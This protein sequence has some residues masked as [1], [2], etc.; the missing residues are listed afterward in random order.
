[1]AL[2]ATPFF[3]TFFMRWIL[4][5]IKY[6]FKQVAFLRKSK[7]LTNIALRS[8]RGHTVKHW[9]LMKLQRLNVVDYVISSEY[10]GSTLYAA[11]P[12][13]L[14]FLS[15]TEFQ[16]WYYCFDTVAQVNGNGWNDVTD[17]RYQFINDVTHFKVF[18]F[19]FYSEVY[20]TFGSYYLSISYSLVNLNRWIVVIQSGTINFIRSSILESANKNKNRKP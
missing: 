9:K 12:I 4:V 13:S 20:S 11:N 18:Y 15:I 6:K 16:K 17:K 5:E 7:I 2:L 14:E 8:Y 1:M 3:V 19:C 10:S